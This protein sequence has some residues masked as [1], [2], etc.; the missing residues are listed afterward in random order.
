M[1]R[2]APFTEGDFQLIDSTAESEF[3]FKLATT[4]ARAKHREI[5]SRKTVFFTEALKLRIN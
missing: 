5:F 3:N 4:I 2:M 1:S